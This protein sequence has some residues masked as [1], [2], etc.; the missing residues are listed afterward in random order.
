M[1][2]AWRADTK[3][4]LLADT[5]DIF[6]SSVHLSSVRRPLICLRRASAPVFLTNGVFSAIAVG[7]N[8]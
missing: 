3:D 2:S 8:P 6:C 7:V 1:V 5:I 4:T